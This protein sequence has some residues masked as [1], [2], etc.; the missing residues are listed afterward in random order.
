MIDDQYISKII[1]SYFKDKNILVNH[2]IE[3]Y[4]HFLMQLDE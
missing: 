2:Q 1:Q 4:N 3:S